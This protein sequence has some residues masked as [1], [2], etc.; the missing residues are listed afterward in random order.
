[1]TP[2]PA[3][4]GGETPERQLPRFVFYTEVIAAAGAAVIIG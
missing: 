2:H 3:Y 1:M 4:R